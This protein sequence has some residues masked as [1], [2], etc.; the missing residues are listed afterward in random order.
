M[1]VRFNCLLNEKISH[2]KCRLFSIDKLNFT[3]G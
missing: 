2:F 3:F 1:L